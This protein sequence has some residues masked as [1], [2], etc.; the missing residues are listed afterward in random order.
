MEIINILLMSVLPSVLLIILV[1]LLIKSPSHRNFA[2]IFGF[3]IIMFIIYFG[4]YMYFGRINWFIW[5]L[6]VI[7]AGFIKFYYLDKN[8]EG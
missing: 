8:V 7:M 4:T 2:T 1:A 3:I 5:I 6:I